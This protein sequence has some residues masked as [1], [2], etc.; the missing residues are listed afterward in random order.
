M[1]EGLWFFEKFT[2]DLLYGYKAEEIY[3]SGR[4]QFQQVDIVKLGVF[5][6]TLFL[7]SKIQSAH[8]DEYIFHESLVV[9][10]LVT[11]AAPRKVMI[12]G[13][14]EG[15]TLRE[16]LRARTV[17]RAVMVDID[18][19]L[20]ELCKQ[21]MPE[22]SAG[23]YED[24]RAEV[25]IGD[26]KEYLWKTEEKFDVIISDLTEPLEG[27]PSVYLFTKEFY[28]RV[29]EVLTD[30]G[31]L[32]VQ[33]GSADPFYNQFLAAIVKTL[34]EVFPYVRPYWAFILS[35][36]MPWGFTLASKKKDPVV[37]T[38]QEVKERVEQLGLEGLRYYTPRMHQAMFVLPPYIEEAVEKAEVMTDERP[39]IWRV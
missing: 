16:V 8:I 24:P 30:D 21:Y 14:G 39:F 38:V 17:E 10:A 19:K 35:F 18:G 22:W 37:L 23:A 7:D 33:S 28:Q 25:V 13:G 27:G 2:D 20:V 32:A 29:Y 36:N 6:K 12:A 3:Y 11:H 4:T 5:G 31:V 26:A 34:K 9:P 15:A 1:K